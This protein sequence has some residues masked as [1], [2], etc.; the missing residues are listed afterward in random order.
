MLPRTTAKDAAFLKTTIKVQTKLGVVVVRRMIYTFQE[1]MISRIH[2]PGA[3]APG[4]LVC[5]WVWGRGPISHRGG[6]SAIHRARVYVDGTWRAWRVAYMGPLPHT[7]SSESRPRRPFVECVCMFVCVHLQL[8]WP[9]EV[10][11]GRSG[12]GTSSRPVKLQT[13]ARM[14]SIAYI[15]AMR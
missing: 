6:R 9:A 8:Q 10:L 2:A 13:C 4:A 15:R 5:V 12:W 1:F 11:D 14:S 3:A 7:Q